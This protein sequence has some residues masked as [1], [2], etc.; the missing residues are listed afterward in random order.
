[1]LS[2]SKINVNMQLQSLKSQQNFEIVKEMNFFGLYLKYSKD[3]FMP[4]L[5]V[6][7]YFT[8]DGIMEPSS[9]TNLPVLIR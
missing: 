3:F 6:I 2:E 9:E 5:N 7:I 8:G 4:K 1:M